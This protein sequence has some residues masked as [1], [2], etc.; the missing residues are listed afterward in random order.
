MKSFCL[1]MLITAAFINMNA[2]A[3]DESA[4]LRA[5]EH[6]SV[7]LA[8]PRV[9]HGIDEDETSSD[10]DRDLDQSTIDDGQRKADAL[11]PFALSNA[12]IKDRIEKN[13]SLIDFLS[14]ESVCLK[15]RYTRCGQ[16]V[17]SNENYYKGIEEA[18]SEELLVPTVAEFIEAVQSDIDTYSIIKR[19]SDSISQ[20]TDAEEKNRAIRHLYDYLSF[21]YKKCEIEEQIFG[22]LSVDDFR[23]K[24]FYKIL[25]DT[26]CKADIE[27]YDF[28][29][30]YTTIGV[31]TYEFESQSMVD[32]LHAQSTKTWV[33][34]EGNPF[35]KMKVKSGK[36]PQKIAEVGAERERIFTKRNAILQRLQLKTDARNA[37]EHGHTPEEYCRII[38]PVLIKIMMDWRATDEEI[39][40]EASKLNQWLIENK[41]LITS[42]MPKKESDKIY[43]FI[44]P[45]QERIAPVTL[46]AKK[47][48][49]KKP[50]VRSETDSAISPQTPMA[51]KAAVIPP[52]PTPPAITPTPPVMLA[53]PEMR[54]VVRQPKL[55]PLT[56]QSVRT[57][58]KKKTRGE[59]RVD[60]IKTEEHEEESMSPTL[61]FA[62]ATEYPDWIEALIVNKH[63]K[64]RQSVVSFLSETSFN[65]GYQQ[66]GDK[67]VFSLLSPIDGKV[68]A[69]TF[70]NPHK[71]VG[72]KSWP[73]W[74]YALY[75]LLVKGHIIDGVIR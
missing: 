43:N 24:F 50:S 31:G 16:M 21:Q 64:I 4:D 55:A 25:R 48:A 28:L 22:A 61:H 8:T 47:P 60:E 59:A 67:Y 26:L 27:K 53:P 63:L 9:V 2:Y 17:G 62:N 72:E 34:L 75:N 39:K 70:H 6:P 12:I 41:G 1:K 54:P 29:A 40:A 58:I 51:E 42:Q 57:E 56:E 37:P 68:H 38:G 71:K 10:S 19:I 69:E 18:A 49:K 36:I 15:D 13:Q 23:E 44:N 66:T 20:S 11:D 14:N 7:S 3:A 46:P 5:K 65:G 74:R 73:S 52:T 45:P 33:L 35:L 30:Q 32:D